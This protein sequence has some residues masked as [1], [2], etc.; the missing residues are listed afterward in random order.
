[1]RIYLFICLYT[2]LYKFFKFVSKCTFPSL[3]KC[4]GWCLSVN[5]VM[6]YLNHGILARCLGD[7]RQHTEAGEGYCER[8]KNKGSQKRDFRNQG[9]VFLLLEKVTKSLY[10]HVLGELVTNVTI[11]S[12]SHS[13]HNVRLTMNKNESNRFFVFL[14]I[15]CTL[16]VYR[17]NCTDLPS[18]A[19]DCLNI[20]IPLNRASTQLFFSKSVYSFE[21]KEDTQPGGFNLRLF[22][23]N[24]LVRIYYLF[25]LSSNNIHTDIL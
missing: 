21:V 11:L 17:V 6:W 22:S 23:F 25:L 7:S 2:F 13:S 1:M 10:L 14:Q 24:V 15:L 20:S 9:I 5:A 12:S 18:S 19:N 3:Y 8:Q 16:S 4:V